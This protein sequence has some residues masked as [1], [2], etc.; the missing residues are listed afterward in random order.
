MYV[1]VYLNIH[2]ENA[3]LPISEKRKLKNR[4]GWLNQNHTVNGG[5]SQ[6]SEFE[7]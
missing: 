2:I 3:I 7:F 4:G 5:R 1:Y 6:T